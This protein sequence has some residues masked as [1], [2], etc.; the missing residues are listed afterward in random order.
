[1]NSRTR[2]ETLHIAE[3][4][5]KQVVVSKP[6]L[7]AVASEHFGK[8]PNC[9]GAGHILETWSKDAV[10]IGASDSRWTSAMTYE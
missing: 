7:T 2:L 4:G 1:M 9:Q 3:V 5:F 10:L 8:S 6:G